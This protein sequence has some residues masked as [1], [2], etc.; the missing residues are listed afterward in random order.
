MSNPLCH[1]WFFYFFILAYTGS[2]QTTGL[3]ANPGCTA[4]DNTHIYIWSF[5]TFLNSGE[6]TLIGSCISFDQCV[7]IKWSWMEMLS[8]NSECVSCYFHSW[9]DEITFIFNKSILHHW[10]LGTNISTVDISRFAWP[11]L[12]K[13]VT[14][15]RPFVTVIY[16]PM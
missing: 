2:S 3:G 16:K 7:R 4:K 13:G 15:F 14:K 5:Q 1:L 9:Q 10:D 8:N 6:I 11:L 12:T